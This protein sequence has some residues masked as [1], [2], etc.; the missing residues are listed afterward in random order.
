MRID[1]HV[2]TRRHSPCSSIDPAA[3]VPTAIQAGLQGVVITEHE[4]QWSQAELEALRRQ[5]FAPEFLVLA[6]FEYRTLRGDLL[7]YGLENEA[8]KDFLPGMTSRQ[9]TEKATALGGA[10]I[11]AHPT[12]AGMDFDLAIADSRLA[13]LEVCSSNLQPHERRLAMKLAKSLEI[14]PVAASDAHAA[15]DIGRYATEFE[16]PV[17]TGAGLQNALR[18]GRFQVSEEVVKESGIW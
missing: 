18:N 11:A 15:K 2:H 12:R 7:V 5:S 6:G 17:E 16:A 13:G 8:Y 14:P 9:A 1:L 10:C 4:Y 3:V